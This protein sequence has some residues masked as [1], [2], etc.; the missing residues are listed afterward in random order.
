MARLF[1]L[2]QALSVLLACAAPGQHVEEVANTNGY[3]RNIVRGTEFQHLI[4]HNDRE[5]RSGV[6]HVYLEHDGSP[7]RN[8]REVARDPTPRNPLMLKLMALDPVPSIYLGRPCY[9]GLARDSGC[10]PVMWTDQR[11]SQ[12][13]VGSM[14][15]ALSSFVRNDPH[16]KFIFFGHSGGGTLAMLLAELFHNTLAVVTLAGNLDIEAWAKHHGYTPLLGSLNPASRPALDK[17]VV[18]RHY[19]ATQDLNIPPALT[20]RYAAS[21]PEAELFEF[22]GFDHHCCWKEVWSGILRRLAIDVAHEIQ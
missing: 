22:T 1:L 12:Q 18:Q 16:A 21:H 8:L 4:Y 14:A 15:K 6:Y 13:V 20:K 3:T 2:M 9:N 5:P 7:W 11:Y 17:R 19:I 10:N